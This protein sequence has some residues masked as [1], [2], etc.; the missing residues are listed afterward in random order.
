[1]PDLFADID[2]PDRAFFKASEVCELLRVQPYVLRSWEAEFPHL[3]VPKG[4]GGRIYRRE[5]VEQVRRIRHLLLVDGLT[6]AGV[7]RKLEDEAEPVVIETPAAE[8]PLGG[9]A[10]EQ[11]A[12]VKQGLRL[13]LELLEPATAGVPGQSSLLAGTGARAG[14]TLRAVPGT[15]RATGRRSPAKSGSAGKTRSA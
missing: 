14:T 15:G 6:L 3:G 9:N 8:P 5:D 4:S 11:L 1:M 13:L 2:I 7:R 10:K 12:A